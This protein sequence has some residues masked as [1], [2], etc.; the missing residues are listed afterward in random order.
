MA[1][2]RGLEVQIE[3]DL[4]TLDG[5][6]AWTSKPMFGGVALLVSGNL[7]CG[8]RAGSLMVRLG[9]GSD[10]WALGLDGLERW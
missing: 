9:K 8:V 6:L 5:S 1:R 3:E 4:A 7:L 10:A 2:D